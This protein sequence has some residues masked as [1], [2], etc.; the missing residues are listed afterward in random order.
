MIGKKY[1]DYVLTKAKINNGTC[2]AARKWEDCPSY[3]CPPPPI[4]CIGAWGVC[5]PNGGL[6]GWKGKKTYKVSQ[7]PQNGGAVCKDADTGLTL[8]DGDIKVCD[9]GVCY[10]GR[11]SSLR[12]KDNIIK[13]GEIDG[14]TVYSWTWNAIAMS[15]YGLKGR[16]VGIIAENLPSDVVITDVYGYM[17]IREGTWA[18]KLVEKIRDIYPK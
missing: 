16:E 8:N 17:N 1:S 18:S 12:L 2:P 11:Q 6:C 15:T 3:A 5:M 10:T 13:I 4:N 14:I 9:L 7:K